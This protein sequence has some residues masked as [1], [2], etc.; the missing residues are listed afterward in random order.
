MLS[1]EKFVCKILDREGNVRG[2]GFFV[3]PDGYII[4]CYHVVK[5]CEGE[6]KVG[7]FYEPKMIIGE[8][9]REYEQYDIA[10][11]KINRENC[12]VIPLSSER[13]QGD[14]IF[15]HG[16]SIQHS[17]KDF[18]EGFPLKPS[19]LS[20][21]TTLENGINLLVLENTNVDNGLSGAPAVNERTDE[22]IG[23]LRLK[24]NEGQTA[25]VI[26]IEYL[27]EM[28][29]ELR[30]YHKSLREK[31]RRDEL[32]LEENIIFYQDKNVFK[33]PINLNQIDYL[34]K[35][36]LI[37]GMISSFIVIADI[38]LNI[39][40]IYFY[41]FIFIWLAI[42][43][44]SL[45]FYL[46]DMKR[47]LKTYGEMNLGKEGKKIILDD[48]DL[49][50]IEKIGECPICHNKVYLYYDKSVH[51]LLGKCSKNKKH[52][53]SFDPTIDWGVPMEISTTYYSSAH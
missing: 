50:I 4:T 18:P 51:E 38:F 40:N 31:K 39:V 7:I 46:W 16:F 41:W 24:F 44:I 32:E 14:K 11:I 26:P 37:L 12:P 23:I 52:L 22:I 25:L 20:G 30:K 10:V 27:F 2:T 36:S 29:A 5:A 33:L 48:N 34:Q 17:R 45:A 3:H 28:C 35:I 8:T 15:S 9:V 53:Y 42:L 43:F 13:K 49:L 47:K 6:V 1:L 19:E 21:T